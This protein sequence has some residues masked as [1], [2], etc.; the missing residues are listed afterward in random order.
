MF[1]LRTR[2]CVDRTVGHDW[3][4]LGSGGSLQIW[5]PPDPSLV[6]FA[7]LMQGADLVSLGTCPASGLSLSTTYSATVGL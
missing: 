6:G 2:R 4:V 5:I 7:F 3:T 1:L